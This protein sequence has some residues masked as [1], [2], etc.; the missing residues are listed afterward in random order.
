MVHNLPA[1]L[2]IQ[3]TTYIM[4]HHINI[5]TDENFP[6]KMRMNENVQN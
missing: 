2:Y 3:T 1:K 4:L 5:Q 6:T